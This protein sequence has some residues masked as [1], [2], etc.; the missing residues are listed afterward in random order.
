MRG[1]LRICRDGI[2][3]AFH[4]DLVASGHRV[5][6]I[7]VGRTAPING[8]RPQDYPRH[9]AS[10]RVHCIGWLGETLLTLS[11]LQA[12]REASRD[13]KPLIACPPT[14][15]EFS[16]ARRAIEVVKMG[17]VIGKHPKVRNRQKGKQAQWPHDDKRD[18]KHDRDQQPLVPRR[19]P[20]WLFR[21]SGHGS[22]NGKD[23]R[24]AALGSA[25]THDDA[26]ESFASCGSQ[27]FIA[28]PIG[29]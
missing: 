13:S 6:L 7:S 1:R 22:P 24:L 3:T 15:E 23:Q 26:R 27:L 18:W 28:Q 20:R 25:I 5:Y 12:T 10:S 14:R 8:S 17:M 21:R 19:P 29:V 2:R 16:L 4:S 9:R 11:D